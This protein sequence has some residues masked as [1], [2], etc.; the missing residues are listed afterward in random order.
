MY[1]IIR[2]GNGKYYTSTV[3]GYCNTAGDPRDFGSRYWIALNR[4]KDAL[5][6]LDYFG[7]GEH[8]VIPTVLVTDFDK[9]GWNT[10]NEHAQAAAFLPVDALLAMTAEK[11]VPEDLLQQCI[12]LDRAYSF[13]P[14]PE[15]T[16][17]AEAQTFMNAVLGLHDACIS[18]LEEKDDS[19]R[20]LFAGE[21][22]FDVEISFSG[23]VCYDISARDPEIYDPYWLDCNVFFRDSYVYLTDGASAADSPEG[24]WFRGKHMHY[25]I[26]PE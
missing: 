12:A 17:E 13:Q 2:E 19:L 15:I 22:G 16:C 1:A 18:E 7:K 21:W 26:I 25:R 20:V 14:C 11:R 24:C 4:E 6:C 3:F 23:D 5:V 10:Q 9:S 8:G